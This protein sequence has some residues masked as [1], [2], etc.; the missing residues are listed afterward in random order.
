[1]SL[2]S[3]DI[4]TIALSIMTVL[5]L[6]ANGILIWYVRKLL[7]AQDEMNTELSENIYA[8]QDE[9][10]TLLNTDVLAGEPTLIKLLDDVREF[11]EKTEEIRLRLIPNQ[12]D[13]ELDVER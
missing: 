12:Q 3:G 2:D 11:G 7:S 4:M 8:F 6:A 13:G 1:M 10:Q 9:L 5:S